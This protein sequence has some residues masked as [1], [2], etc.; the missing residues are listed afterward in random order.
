MCG[1]AQR[2]KATEEVF[3]ALLERHPKYKKTEKR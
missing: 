3:G 1:F 2:I